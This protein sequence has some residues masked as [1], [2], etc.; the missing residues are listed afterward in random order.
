MNRE[1]ASLALVQKRSLASLG[2]PAST[3]TASFPAFRIFP[4]GTVPESSIRTETPRA[5]LTASP[6]CPWQSWPEVA[7]HW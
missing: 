2:K 6:Q 1:Q 5:T 7:A 3:F 4:V